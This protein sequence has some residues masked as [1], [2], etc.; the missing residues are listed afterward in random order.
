MLRRIALFAT[1]FSF[2][3]GSKNQNVFSKQVRFAAT[4][5]KQQYEERSSGGLSTGWIILFIVIALVVVV[6]VTA[7]VSDDYSGGSGFGGGRAGYSVKDFYNGKTKVVRKVG[8][9]ITVFSKV[10]EE[11]YK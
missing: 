11:D 7:Y 2:L 9:T 8:L 10:L 3:F 1:F 4:N 5:E 6:I